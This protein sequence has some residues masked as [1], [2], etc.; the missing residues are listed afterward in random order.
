MHQF[1]PPSRRQALKSAQ[2]GLG[3]LAL[4]GRRGEPARAAEKLAPAPLA[5]KAKRLIFG[6]VGGAMSQ[7]DTFEYT[8]QLFKDGGEPGPGG[9]TLAAPRFKFAQHGDT[10]AWFSELL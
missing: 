8:P 4:G 1:Q 6:H 5:P 3:Y 7:H 10:G 9:G 2:A